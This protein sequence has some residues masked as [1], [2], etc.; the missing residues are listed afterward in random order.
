MQRRWV[1]LGLILILLIPA[2][3]LAQDSDSA[4]CDIDLSGVTAM[5][6]DADEALSD[7]DQEAALAT[8]EEAQSALDEILTQCSSLAAVE[9]EA[10]I[11][12]APSGDFSLSY[13]AEWTVNTAFSDSG[14]GTQAYFATSASAMNALATPNPTLSSGEQA[15]TMIILPSMMFGVAADT[16]TDDALDQVV[17]TLG[18]QLPEEMHLGDVSEISFGDASARRIELEGDSF[19]GAMMIFPLEGDNLAVFFALAAPDEFEALATAVEQMAMS[20]AAS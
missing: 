4:V 14:Q 3:V 2:S 8:L 12:N 7:G 9:F 20:Y 13:P 19:D 5:I 17:D 1:A 18:S 10:A 16:P 15:V 6:A 11:Y